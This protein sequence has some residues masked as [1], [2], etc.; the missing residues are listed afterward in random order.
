MNMKSLKTH[1]LWFSQGWSAQ[2]AVAIGLLIFL[3]GG[4]SILT[5]LAEEKDAEGEESAGATSDGGSDSDRGPDGDP[6]DDDGDRERESRSFT[7]DDLDRYHRPKPEPKPEGVENDATTP[8][9]KKGAVAKSGPRT[10]TKK[11]SALPPAG[12]RGHAPMVRTPLKVA[13]PPSQDPLKKFRD[14]EARERFR[15]EQIQGLR[16]Q[17]EA[18]EKRLD[19]LRGKWLAVVNPLYLMPEPPPGET[20]DDDAGL[21][22]QELLDRIEAEITSIEAEIAT[23]RKTLVVIE[24]RFG[25][26]ANRR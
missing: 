17:I 9:A 24:T 22:P 21:K 19:Y 11:Q 5:T 25:H 26:E 23:T 18:L 4:P 16:D 12:P 7:N 13:T 3:L 8:G 20:P 6:E 15:T 10:L 14:K 1:R 2:G